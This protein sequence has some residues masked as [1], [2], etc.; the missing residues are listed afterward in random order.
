[1][2]ALFKVYEYAT[3]AWKNVKA[4]LVDGT[5]DEFI[6]GVGI[7]GEMPSGS[8]GAVKVDANRIIRTSPVG[9][10]LFWRYST[11]L[12]A[13]TDADSTA[14]NCEDYTRLIGCWTSDTTGNV[15]IEQDEDGSMTAGCKYVTTYALEA[16][17]IDGNARYQVA[18]DQQLMHGQVRITLENT[19]VSAQTVSMFAAYKT[20]VVR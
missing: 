4:L 5:V 7:F 13:G 14:L 8:H 12:T 1:M 6:A 3:S 18:F 15:I 17:T 16:V 11:L 19:S 10:E 20:A 2:E 9:R